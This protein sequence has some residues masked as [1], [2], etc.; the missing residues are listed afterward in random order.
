MT[1]LA[2]VRLE[3]SHA[4]L[5][6]LSASHHDELVA[7]SEDG[8]LCTLWYTSVPSPDGVMAEIERLLTLQS[9]DKML[10]FAVADSQGVIVGIT[11]FMNP[12]P[13]H[14]RL[15]IGTTWYAKRVQRT[16]LNTQ[17][18]LLLMQHAFEALDCIAVELRTS[19]ANRQS[20]RA[21]ERLGAKLDGVL[22]SHQR[23]KNGTLRDTCVYSVIA[24]EWPTV[25]ASLRAM[26]EHQA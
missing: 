13:I 2:P 23:H 18:K 21:I 6:P 7:A 16:M 22:R 4:T 1:W 10:P 11:T 26:L 5:H 24:C 20:R 25:K 17:C 14:R 8:H 9:Q 19:Y 3:G 12:D 15:E